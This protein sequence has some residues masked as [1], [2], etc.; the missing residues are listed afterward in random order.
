M[1]PKQLLTILPN[2]GRITSSAVRYRFFTSALRQ[3]GDVPSRLPGYFRGNESRKWARHMRPDR[4]CAGRVLII[5]E[6][7]PAGIDHRVSKQIDSLVEG[8]YV[9]RVITQRHPGNDIFRAIS[10]VRL[11]EYPSPTEP[12]GLL[13]YVREYGYSFVMAAIL[14]MRVLAAGRIDIV[15]FC[16]PPDVYFLLA[17]VFRLAGARVVVDQ[18]DLLPELYAAR[19]GR[20]RSGL[21]WVLGVCEKLSQRSADR[22]ICVNDHMRQRALAVS[23]LPAPSIPV[24][25]NG[26]ELAMVAESIGDIRLKKGRQHLCCWAGQISRQDRVDLLIRSIHQVVHGLGRTDCQFAV[27]GQGECLAEAR[28]LARKLKVDDW[29]HFPGFVPRKQ[30]FQYLA[31]ADLGVDASLQSDVSPV[32]AMEYMAFALPFVA[33]DLPETRAIGDGAAVFVRPGDVRDHAW[34]IAALLADPNRRKALGSVGQTRVCDELAWDHQA[35]TY[36]ATLDG[37]IRKPA[38]DRPAVTSLG[39][40]GAA[41]RGVKASRQRPGWNPWA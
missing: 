35:V 24:V 14:S 16:Q 22:I 32:K 28:S 41:R 30:V 17:P 29:V 10:A 9:V 5:V 12:S 19:Y 20:A 38:A 2:L 13:G 40:A 25:R 4:N 34:N 11:F 15:Q 33:F 18:R 23:G 26:P 37:L 8:G 6:N 21:R 31:T 36:L 7:V 27:I 39:S 3:L 1:T